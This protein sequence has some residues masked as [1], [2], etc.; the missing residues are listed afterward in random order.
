MSAEEPGRR[1]LARIGRAAASRRGR[2]AG[3]L[4][5]TPLALWH[6]DATDRAA[7]LTY[8]A[9]LAIF[10]A[11]LVT[12]CSIGLAGPDASAQ[13]A[14]QVAAIVPA[15]SQSLVRSSLEEMTQQRSAAWLLASFGTVGAM[16]S[17]SSYLGVFRRGL[18]AMHGAVDHR[19]P[20]RTAPRIALTALGMLTLLVTSALTLILTGEA[21]DTLGRMLGM[22]TTVS[23]VWR[24][25][26]W[27]LLLAL[28]AVL[29]LM[30]FRTG[31]VGTRRLRRS[32]PGGILAVALWL[33]TSAGFAVYTSHAGTYNR[34]YGSLA[35]VIVFLV[36]L[37]VTNLSLLAGAQFNAELARG[38]APEPDQDK[39][40][41]PV[42]APPAAPAPTPAS[43]PA[44]AA[45]PQPQRAV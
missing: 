40:E 44:P 13:L 3:A 30:V 4:R 24:M 31:P 7:A 9:V 17:A 21:A 41:A 6:D 36:W 42:S 5:R 15:Q 29:V 2:L 45:E 23:L 39:E 10:P 43:M 8:Y 32:L 12:V 19:P 16:W 27:P 35:G 14:D 38:A 1:G 22:G 11:L 34:L 18:H 37:W 25:M 26:K 28:A 33:L 20:W